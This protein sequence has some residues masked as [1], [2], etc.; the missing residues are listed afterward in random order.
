MYTKLKVKNVIGQTKTYI[1]DRT[2]TYKNTKSALRKYALEN[3]NRVFDFKN[4]EILSKEANL[5]N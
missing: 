3:A 1:R 4:T 5:K 2:R